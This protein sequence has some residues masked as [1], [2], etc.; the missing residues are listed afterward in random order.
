MN[1]FIKTAQSAVEARFSKNRNFF[2]GG[3]SREILKI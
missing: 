1:D 3:V 2:F